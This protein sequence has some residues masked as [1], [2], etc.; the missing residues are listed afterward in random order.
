MEI[1]EVTGFAIKKHFPS[2][3]SDPKRT[4]GKMERG[5]KKATVASFG[6]CWN[7]RA[8]H[9]IGGPPP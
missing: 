4:G 8:C 1:V 2:H 5:K 9:S 7:A 6:H 3:L